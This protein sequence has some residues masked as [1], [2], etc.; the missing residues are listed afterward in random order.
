MIYRV[1]VILDS[2]EDVVRDIALDSESSFEDFHNAIVQS[3]G[4][5]GLEMASF[6]DSNE[7][8]EQ[9]EELSLFG[10]YD[11][12]SQTLSMAEVKIEDRLENPHDRMLY[13]YDFLNMWTFFVE[14]I[15]KADKTDS[16]EIYPQLISTLGNMPADK[17]DMQF[18][19]DINDADID[20]DDLDES[21]DMFD[22][23]DE[24]DFY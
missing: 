6:F 19:S 17:P 14:L 2:E 8:W 7:A 3:F 4:L 12:S 21:D 16:T 10:M 23:Y 15:E 13:I 20:D 11:N 24:D 18:E 5:D 1:R 9:G 22:D